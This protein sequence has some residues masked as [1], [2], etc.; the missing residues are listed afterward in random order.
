MVRFSDTLYD[1]G[2]LLAFNVLKSTK[3]KKKY[4]NNKTKM[5][6]K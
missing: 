2:D 4:Q 5:L 6:M 1:T 3:N